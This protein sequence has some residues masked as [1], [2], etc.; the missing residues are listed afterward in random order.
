MWKIIVGFL[1]VFAGV[2]F[3]NK[4]TEKYEKRKI[5]FKSLSGYAAFLAGKISFDG[6]TL[7]RSTLNYPFCS[8][9]LKG[10]ATRYVGKRSEANEEIFPSY[11]TEDEI[12]SVKEFFLSLGK[13]DRTSQSETL[14]K[15]SEKYEKESEKQGK[16]YEKKRR[17]SIKLGF[18][19]GI[20]FFI[21]LV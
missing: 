6:E 10:I 20:C 8:K 7:P 17:I 2:Y 1:L 4:S 18:L 13:T 19:S 3:G 12:I 9:D 15:L 14:L 11:L 16:E 21:V 5:F